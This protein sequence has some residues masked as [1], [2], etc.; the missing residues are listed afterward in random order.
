[1]LV[2]VLDGI[3][4]K[5]FL[6]IIYLVI[7]GCGELPKTPPAINPVPSAKELLSCMP[8]KPLLKGELY[9]LAMVDFLQE[10]TDKAWW[11]DY[12]RW[13]YQ[14]EISPDE[15]VE[16]NDDEVAQ[17]CGLTYN[18]LGKPKAITKERCY[19][20]QI[21]KYDGYQDFAY[22]YKGQSFE[23]FIVD[24]EAKVYRPNIDEPI[25]KAENYNK[26]VDFV[27]I[28]NKYFESLYP[29]DCC[30]LISYDEA[31]KKKAIIRG[32]E[33]IPKSQLQNFSV[34]EVKEW[35]SKFENNG[36]IEPKERYHFFL[37]SFCGK[38]VR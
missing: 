14:Q 34:L 25:Y 35:Y 8:D 28:H 31:E 30:K 3:K 6:F 7:C 4:M 38:I 36:K 21:K 1:M 15:R 12:W 27:L 19:P 16:L 20:Y 22:K 26:D 11:G 10:E 9:E 18:W 5:K 33:Y 37:V 23:Q 2:L 29:K 13:K 32:D 17:L 24:S